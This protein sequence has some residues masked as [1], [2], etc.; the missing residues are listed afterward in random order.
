M[1]T[2]MNRT[3]LAEHMRQ[4]DIEDPI[5]PE[6]EWHYDDKEWWTDAELRDAHRT[7]HKYQHQ[8]SHTHEEGTI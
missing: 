1:P 4:H 5:Q 8:L 6:Y 2:Y 7:D 3:E